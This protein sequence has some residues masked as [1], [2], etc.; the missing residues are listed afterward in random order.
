MLL[1]RGNIA[2]DYKA[3]LVRV[4]EFKASKKLNEK[5]VQVFSPLL[6]FKIFIQIRKK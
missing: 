1:E 2:E 5:A 4:D 6:K 3:H